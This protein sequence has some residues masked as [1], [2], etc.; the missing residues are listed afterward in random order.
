MAGKPNAKLK[1]ETLK[2]RGKAIYDNGSLTT[3]QG[4]DFFEDE[5]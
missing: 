5:Q 1:I 4:V 2:Q 3:R